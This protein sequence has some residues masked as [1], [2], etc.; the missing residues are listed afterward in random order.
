[1]AR[2]YWQ[3][4]E[5]TAERFV[6][7]PFSG[8]AGRRLYRTG[9]VVR[10]QSDGEL[11]YLGRGDQ[12]V[13][14]R[15]YRI[16]LGEIE[17]VLRRQVGVRETVVVARAD[18]TG[19]Q[20]LVA[21][22]VADVMADSGAPP[23]PQLRVSGWRRALKGELPEYMVPAA[24]V[25]LEELPLTPNGKV[26]RK[27]LPA[28]DSSCLEVSPGYQAPSTEVEELLAGIWSQVLGVGAIGVH[29]N[30]F[31]L[32]G[33]SLLATQLVARVRETFQ[34]EL[35]LPTLFEAPTVAG[36][37][38]RLEAALLGEHGVA[39]PVLPVKRDQPLPLSY[40]QQRASPTTCRRRCVLKGR[41]MCRHW[42]ER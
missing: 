21:Y 17:A 4:P 10:Y 32:G 1:L 26:D 11:E 37:A 13:K 36:L 40:A 20:R 15:G 34:V 38:T 14:L 24:F 3:R 16:E 39:S 5:L 19:A 8:S 42:Q 30:F 33:H 22:V 41:L 7:D 12:Q 31:E 25:E 28:P 27:A 35:P 6:P 2:G 9:D 29:D 23:E 18:G